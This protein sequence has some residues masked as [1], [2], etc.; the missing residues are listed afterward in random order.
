MTCPACTD[1]CDSDTTYCGLCGDR[2]AARDRLVGTVLDE[3]FRIEARIAAGG[4]G[5]IYRATMLETGYEVAVKVLHAQH[6][7]D[8]SV[9]A[10]FRREAL[11]MSS[12]SDPHTVTTYELGED[13][14]GTQFIVMELLHGESLADRFAACGSLH[15]RTVLSIVRDACSSLA[16]A[17][18]LGIV[19]RDLKPANIFLAQEPLRDFVKILDFGIAKI[20]HRSNMH[21]GAELTRI[22]QAIGTLE[23]MS[24]EQLVGADLDGR[25]DIYTLGVVAYEMITG[26]RP[27]NDVTGAT[28]LVTALMTRQPPPPSTVSRGPLPP[29][30][31]GVLLRCLER[32]SKDRFGD[33]RELARALDRMLAIPD[34]VVTTQRLWAKGEP[35]VFVDGDEE[36]TW[37]DTRLPFEPSLE[38]AV[39]AGF[40][41][42]F[43]E[44]ALEMQLAQP[45]FDDVVREQVAAKTPERSWRVAG[46][47]VPGFDTPPPVTGFEVAIESTNDTATPLPQLA[48]GSSPTAGPMPS[49]RRNDLLR[50]VMWTVLLAGVG[51]GLGIAIA[52]LA[53]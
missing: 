41:P 28:A 15:W 11:T 50:I 6:N 22:G 42:V 29:E 48:I 40:Q 16:E 4:F 14:D 51:L 1:R 52:S 2:I 20:L 24:P 44:V 9:S 38:H 34:D 49:A 8:P 46:T 19:H 43:Q 33:V 13:R 27:F 31:D 18:E 25:T 39:K 10:R 53:T 36:L 3:R 45:L 12:L 23:Y 30:L 35:A 17:H 37:I 7:A 26:R 47:G 32:E 5:T 21:D